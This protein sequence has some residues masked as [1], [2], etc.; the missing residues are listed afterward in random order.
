MARIGSDNDGDENEGGDIDISPLIDC[1]FIL[2][3]FFIVTTVFVKQPDVDIREPVAVS[4]EDLAKNSLII[5]V[6]ADGS[7]VYGG[8]SIG[9][10]GVQP[11]VRRELT[12]G[13]PMPVIIK[14]D[15]NAPNGVLVR[16]LEEAK[17]AGAQRVNF[18]TRKG[19]GGS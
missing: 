7:V 13:D 5:A 1:V 19:G 12:S 11:L 18:A 6:T 2:L 10:A 8:D 3:I 17:L 15:E 16:V 9:L 14:P 4:A